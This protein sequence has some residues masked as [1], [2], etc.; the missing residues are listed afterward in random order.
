[1]KTYA[2]I[3]IVT[4]LLFGLVDHTFGFDFIEPIRG[5]LPLNEP[6]YESVYHALDILQA[7]GFLLQT[8][9]YDRPYSA[10][11]IRRLLSQINPDKLGKSAKT[12]YEYL[13]TRLGGEVKKDIT[14][15]FEAYGTVYSTGDSTFRWGLFPRVEYRTRD[16]FFSTRYTV[17]SALEDNPRYQ[18]K[19]WRGFGGYGTSVYGAYRTEKLNIN[20]GRRRLNWGPGKT[21]SMILSGYSMPYDGLE[22]SY[23]IHRSIQLSAVSIVL[24]SQRDSTGAYEQRYLSG[25]RLIIKP[26]SR[27]TLGFSEFV[28]YGGVGRN[29]EVYYALPLFFLHGAQLNQGLDDNTLIEADFR[30]N[31]MSATQIY[32]QLL[33]DDIQVESKTRADNEPSEYGLLLGLFHAGIP[34]LELFDIRIE[35]AR[36]TNWTYNQPHDRNKYLN[37]GYEIGHPLG[38]DGD[39]IYTA[40]TCRPSTKL[41]CELEYSYRRN[42]EGSIEAVWDEPWMDVPEY[43]EDFPT[44]V[45]EKTHELKGSLE[46]LHNNH[47]LGSISAWYGDVSNSGNSGGLD[48]DYS[49]AQFTIKMLF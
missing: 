10:D 9:F 32:G 47:L 11:L 7:H 39:M 28:I 33:I 14:A 26:Y 34:A 15:G 31:L 3:F 37:R 27:L 16:F 43:S 25:H 36:V 17:E 38:N 21:G 46:Y 30:L 45:V 44:G 4:I 42:G 49:G 8:R 13:N 29:P 23:N 41:I 35:Y 48:E 5:D 6:A 22:L 40:L 18:G 20:F 19:K 24:D 12:A 2:V 1:M